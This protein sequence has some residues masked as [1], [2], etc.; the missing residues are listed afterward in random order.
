MRIAIFVEDDSAVGL[1]GPLAGGVNE[2]LGVRGCLAQCPMFSKRCADLDFDCS[3]FSDPALTK[4]VVEKFKPDIAICA[5]CAS[6]SLLTSF[7]SVAVPKKYMLSIQGGSL[8]KEAPWPEFVPIWCS[9]KNSRVSLLNFD[10][11]D[12]S[13]IGAVEVP[14][15]VDDT[16]LSLRA[17]HMEAA[18]R[19]VDSFFKE[20]LARPP[21]VDEHTRPEM[22]LPTLISLDWEPNVVNRFIRAS[23]MP[24]HKPA[25]IKD[26]LTGDKYYVESMMQFSTFEAKLRHDRGVLVNGKADEP[27]HNVADTHWYQ[28]DSKTGSLVK[29]GDKN[30]HMPRRSDDYAKRAIPGASISGQR[31]R[32]RLNEP[33]IG[34]N[35]ERYCGEALASTWIG[36]EG[37]FVKKFESYLATICG[38]QAAVAVQS[39]TAALYGAIKALGVSESSHYVLC[40]SFTCAAAA[41]AV[42]HAGGTPIA[43]DSE[44]DT[45]GV[46]AEAVRAALDACPDVVGVVIAHCYG[47][48][49]R[50]FYEVYEICN[51]RG[52]WLCED[53]CESYGAFV[54]PREKASND[55]V[56]IGSL[57]K[58]NVISTRAEKM[59][60]VGEGGAIVGN[61]CA[62]VALAKWW[63]SRAPCKGAGLWRVYEHE[64]VGQNFRLPELLGCVGCA[65]AEMLP[66]MIERKRRIHDWYCT[67]LRQ[68]GF[69]D[70]K[71]QSFAEGDEPVWWVNTALMPEGVSGEEIGMKVINDYPDIE[72]RPGFFPL[73]QMAIFKNR[74][75]QPCPISDLLYRRI[76]CLPSSVN[77]C[78]E[79]VQ[80]I[81]VALEDA[82]R[83]V[84]AR[85]V[86]SNTSS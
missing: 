39:G 78:E 1:L 30:P 67:Y 62:L 79:D 85:P 16:A 28:L 9:W 57:G 12:G 55:P 66:T 49:I 63:C 14:L 19:L 33:L 17:K 3:S 44:I 13:E 29:A 24:P 68:P 36:V 22:P 21:L 81:C 27:T 11:C 52:I 65:A 37:P 46:S 42:V 48:P 71:L 43:I 5:P 8:C 58:L 84:R 74:F 7:T 53:A 54:R 45:Y 35:A 41:D 80:R 15:V 59:I 40:P 6:S 32:L 83:T 2:V 50:D 47:V 34:P 4:M 10:N 60:G 61:D 18:A 72:I 73:D 26:P 20:S 51:Q 23:F 86:A 56:P 75:S 70:V 31:K 38:C 69:E 77:I 82:L 76:I 64:A 25:E